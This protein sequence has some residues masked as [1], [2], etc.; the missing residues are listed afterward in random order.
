MR[1]SELSCFYDMQLIERFFQSVKQDL[2]NAERRLVQLWG[3]SNPYP[4]KPGV[5]LLF[6][7]GKVIYVGETGDLKERMK[8]ITRTKNHSFRRTYGEFLFSIRDGFQKATSSRNFP[9][10]FED[11]LDK[12][13]EERVRVAVFPIS[14]G[15]KEFEDWFTS[16]QPDLLN[17]REKRG[18]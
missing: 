1:A 5:Y 13:I 17:K 4:N 16:N 11:E 10:P 7:R 15:R 18:N 14:I 12:V 9:E 2:E 3:R 8:D 6:E